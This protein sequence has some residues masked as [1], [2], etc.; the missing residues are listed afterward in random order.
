MI[1][2][3]GPPAVRGGFD[4][5]KGAKVVCSCLLALVVGSIGDRGCRE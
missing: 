2:A 4:Y 3:D 5:A 1:W